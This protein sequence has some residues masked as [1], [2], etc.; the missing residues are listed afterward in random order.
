MIGYA[1]DL[2]VLGTTWDKRYRGRGGA[3]G[4]TRPKMRT[5]IVRD[6]RKTKSKRKCRK[7]VTLEDRYDP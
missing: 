6:K 1:D 5:R 7:G 2:Y 3:F 4:E